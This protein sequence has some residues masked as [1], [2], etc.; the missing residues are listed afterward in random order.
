[1]VFLGLSLDT[2]GLRTYGGTFRVLNQKVIFEVLNVPGGV[3]GLGRG[4]R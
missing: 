1:M 4:Y 2:A 3:T